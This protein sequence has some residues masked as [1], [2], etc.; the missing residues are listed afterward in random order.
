MAKKIF[1]YRGKKLED[2]QAMS[3]KEFAELLPS[4]QRRKI[5]RG[6]TEEEKKF[7]E[8]IKNKDNVKTHLRDM[9]ILPEMIGKTVKIHTGKEFQTITLQDETLGHILGEL[10]LSRKKVGHS[11]PGVGSTKSSGSVSV[12]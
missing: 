7:L 8:K 6:L 9:I 4:K 3:H 10:A 12:R 11:A 2:L 5:K 1:A